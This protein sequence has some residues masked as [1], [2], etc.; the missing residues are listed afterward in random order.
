MRLSRLTPLDAPAVLELTQLYA[1][2]PD[3]LVAA[4]AIPARLRAKVSQYMV[5]MQ[6]V[7]AEGCITTG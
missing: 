6:A 2:S 1:E 5:P 4:G 7:N 3:G